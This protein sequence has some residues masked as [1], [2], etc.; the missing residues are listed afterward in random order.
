[1]MA[2]AKHGQYDQERRLP[3]NTGQAQG[4]G[5]IVQFHAQIRELLGEEA[6]QALIEESR[7]QGHRKTAW[8]CERLQERGHVDLVQEYEQ[9]Q[10]DT[11]AALRIRKKEQLIA[12]CQATIARNDTPLEHQE[13]LQTRIAKAQKYLEKHRG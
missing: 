10:R 13:F 4:S 2:R 9:S 1:M 8:L 5:V 11:G 6:G 7:A 3:D 12:Q